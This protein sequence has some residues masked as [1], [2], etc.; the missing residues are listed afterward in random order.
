MNESYPTSVRKLY[1]FLTAC[2]GNWRNTIHIPAQNHAGWLLAADRDGRP[3]VVDVDAFQIQIQ[4]Q[5]DVR[6]CR[7]TLSESGFRDVFSQYLL[8]QMQTAGN[9]PLDAL[10]L[11]SNN[12]SENWRDYT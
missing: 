2:G 7:G 11:L 12:F 10:N 8:W 1:A 6:E 3:L 4:E 9:H 5:I